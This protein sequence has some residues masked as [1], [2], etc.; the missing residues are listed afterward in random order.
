MTRA[1]P[2]AIGTAV[3]L[4]VAPTG[5]A[6][7]AKPA[8]P[9]VQAA[10][11]PARPRTGRV[12]VYLDCADCFPEFLRDQIKFVD[13][14][15]QAQDA[16]VHL[17]A[18]VSDTGG[19]GRETVLRFVGRGRFAGHDE[20]LKAV[21]LV[22]DAES[23]RRDLILRTVQVGLLAFM[24]REGLPANVSVEVE[25]EAAQDSRPAAADRWN[26]WVFSISGS[27]DLNIEE[28]QRD[29]SWNLDFGADRITEAWKITIG[30]R[31]DKETEEFDLDEDEPLKA[32]QQERDANWFVARSLG[33]NWSFGVDGRAE[34][35][36]FENTVFALTLAPAIE[37]SFFPYADYA[38]RQLRLQYSMGFQHAQYNEVTLYGQIRETR[39]AHAASI[40]LDRREPWGSLDVSLE[41]SQYLHDLSKYRIELNG[42]GSFRV[43]RGLSLD[44]D[45]GISRIRDQLSLPRR[46]ATQEE[47]LLRLRELQSAY[48]I[49]FDVGFT[50][51]FGSIFNNIVNPR[52]GR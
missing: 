19:G 43:A 4:L 34:S 21:S 48:E 41:F 10:Q 13:F 50:Y 47:V 44:I 52:F 45:G 26:S 27:A 12:R 15:R 42:E 5:T 1:F 38:T 3:F 11:A 2:A 9:A 7:Q 8:D 24:A 32:I 46:D 28:T 29:R 51:S 39:P 35:S 22:A 18:S 33:P 30:V 20:E 17:L 16:D 49:S 37:Y 36:T 40:T 14:V 6:A 25:R 23:T 31:F